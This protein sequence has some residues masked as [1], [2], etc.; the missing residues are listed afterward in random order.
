MQARQK[1]V[2]LCTVLLFFSV[3]AY[4]SIQNQKARE[5]QVHVSPHHYDFYS[6]DVVQLFPYTSEEQLY[7][8]REV[9]EQYKREHLR[10]A[11][12]GDLKAGTNN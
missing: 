9:L 10:G 5:A 4:T 7:N 11:E 8:Q 12:Q 1:P 2:L 3:I 6:A